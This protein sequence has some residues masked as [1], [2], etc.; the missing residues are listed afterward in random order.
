MRGEPARERMS[1]PWTSALAPTRA[2]KGTNLLPKPIVS[3]A[4][5]GNYVNDLY[6][7]TTNPNRVGTGYDG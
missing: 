4:K 7:G 2:A 6:K 5:L 3:D 1:G